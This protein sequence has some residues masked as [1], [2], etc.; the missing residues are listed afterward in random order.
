MRHETHCSSSLCA[1][2]QLRCRKGCAG[3]GAARCGMQ[4]TH[5]SA[6]LHVLSRCRKVMH[7]HRRAWRS[8]GALCAAQRVRCLCVRV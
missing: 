5:S 6:A 8:S 3:A 1:V 7:G 4:H 2:L